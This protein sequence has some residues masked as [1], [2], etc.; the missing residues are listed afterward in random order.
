MRRLCL[1]LFHLSLSLL[2]ESLLALGTERLVPIA[3]ES[4]CLSLAL[5]LAKSYSVQ[6]K[7]ITVPIVALKPC[8]VPVVISWDIDVV[9]LALW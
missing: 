6:F 7:P 9:V 1:C 4:F 2:L 8:I 3:L 5:G